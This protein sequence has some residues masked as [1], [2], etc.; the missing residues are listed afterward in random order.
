MLENTAM[1]D[2]RSF[3][4]CVVGTAGAAIA[5]GCASFCR[6]AEF[7]GPTIGDRIWM[8]GHHPDVVRSGG[9]GF[10]PGQA[11]I[12]Q[13]AA[14][15]LMGVRNNCVIRWRN[16][17]EYPWGDYF[18]QFKS[19]KRFA[20]GIA[21]GGEESTAEKMRIAFDE[22]KPRYPNMTGCFLDD[23]FIR[24]HLYMEPDRLAEVADE[25]HAHDLRLSIV[26]YSDNK[27]M[28]PEYRRH[29][30]LCD[31]TSLWFWCGDNIVT[32]ADNVRRCR[33]FV[34]ARKDLL[35][36]LYMWDFS[37]S[38][39]ITPEKMEMQLECASRFLADRTLDGLIF[40]P[41]FVADLDI[42]AVRMAKAWIAAN[43]EKLWGV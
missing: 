4:R 5:G 6:T 18:D 13:A 14:C 33:E 41:T 35:L 34:G 39:A 29:L 42:P 26:L 27:G 16:K 7:Y 19:L 24:K 2:R 37:R 30:S 9:N 43:G 25:V 20:F 10:K 40:H 32:M 8:W 12:D 22:L 11:T 21:D 23:F 15:R 31:E 36:G 17:P 3:V 38:E 28:R 1:T